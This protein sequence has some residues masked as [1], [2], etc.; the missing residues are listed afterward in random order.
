MWNAYGPMGGC[1]GTILTDRWV[2]TAA[3]CI[4]IPS[5]TNIAVEYGVS[6]VPTATS[7]VWAEQIYIHPSWNT[8]NIGNGHDVGL[9]YLSEALDMNYAGTIPLYDFDSLPVGTAG[10]V[11]GWGCMW[12]GCNYSSSPEWLQG[13]SVQIV[14]CGSWE[15][16]PINQVCA[17]VSYTHLTLPTICSV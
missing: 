5:L 13:A 3:H 2:L 11:T 9:I 1:G 8:N 16:V 10:Y 17:P 4:D 7:Y 15:P 14:S 6:R 12:T